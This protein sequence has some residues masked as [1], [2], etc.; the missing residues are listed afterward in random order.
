MKITALSRQRRDNHRVNVFIDGKYRLSLN[1]SQIIDMKIKSGLEI[2]EDFII[3]LEK[4]SDFGKIYY[5]ALNYCLI[6]PRSSKELKQYLTKNRTAPELIERIINKMTEKGYQDDTV[7]SKYWVDN[8]MLKKGISQRKLA[9]ELKQKGIEKDIIQQAL[10]N[11]ERNDDQEI[12]KLILKKKSK[13]PP[14][15]LLA[16]MV[17]QGFDFVKVKEKINQLGESDTSA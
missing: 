14:D 16:Y 13:Y 8:R 5:R 15:K 1:E 4:E 7:F 11:S 12:E 6:R 10:E 2:D 17:R 9:Y 3:K